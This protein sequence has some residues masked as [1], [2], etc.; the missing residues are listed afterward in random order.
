MEYI[1]LDDQLLTPSDADILRII[2]HSPELLQENY[3]IKRRYNE[4]INIL[5]KLTIKNY[6]ITVD[7]VT[8]C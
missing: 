4:I 3:Y 8:V 6:N 5:N 1:N 7:A 2:K